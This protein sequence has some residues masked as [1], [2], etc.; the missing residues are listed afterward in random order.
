MDKRLR[1]MGITIK[2]SF[3][4]DDGD[5]LEPGPDVEPVQLTRE[6]AAE[7]IRDMD[8]HVAAL[9]SKTLDAES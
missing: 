3:V 2:P 6:A 9:E 1:L 5:T 8:D 7:M 4:W